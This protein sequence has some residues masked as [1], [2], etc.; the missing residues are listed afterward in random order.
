MKPGFM[1]SV[2][3]K[4]TLAELIATAKQYGYQGIEFR[5]EWDHQHGVELGA[6]PEQLQ[7]ARQLL[8]DNGIAASCIATSVKFN[9]PDRDA[10]LPQRETLRKYIVLAAAIGAPYIRTF[11]DSVPEDDAQARDHVLSLAAESY[12]SVD[13][14]ARQHG[15][16]VL[17]ETHTNMRGHWA[18]QILD[19]AQAES[20][21]VLW[22]IGHH[23]SRGQSVDEAY[24]YIRG[25]VRH[26]HFSATPGKSVTDAENQRTFELLAPD[27][28]QGFFSVEVINP[29]DSNAVLAHHIAKF[30][31]F[32]Q[33]VR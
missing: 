12:A 23:V 13:E 29:E 16:T 27:G 4:Q 28:F 8:A 20:L 26:L 22:H 1:T 30:N 32:M 19:E 24:P 18:R 2:C 14:W 31:E 9:S 7:A 5:V 3:P 33:A 15:I 10:H 6:T 21:Q 17:V 25:H 11:S